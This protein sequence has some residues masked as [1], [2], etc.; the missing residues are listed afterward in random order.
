MFEPLST[1]SWRDSRAILNSA[2]LLRFC[3]PQAPQHFVQ[4]YSDDSTLTQNVAFLLA[5]TLKAGESAV[6]IATQSHLEAI[7]KKLVVA[8][9]DFDHFRQADRYIP[10]NATELLPDLL[11]DGL[12]DQEKFETIVGGL[13]RRAAAASADGYVF[14]FGELV[15]VLC[16][17][18]NAIG[19]LR[20]EQLWNGVARKSRFSLYCGYPIAVT[21][22]DPTL[23]AIFHICAEHSITIPAETS[24]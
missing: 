21:L 15:A 18:K 13:L 9:I 16:D 1:L 6:I 10:V 14:A 22:S 19:A 4:F 2:D 5:H 23:D 3:R 7:E 24:L 17:R 11:V 20:L 12:P 8:G